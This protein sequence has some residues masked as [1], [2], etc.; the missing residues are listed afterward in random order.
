MDGPTTATIS[1]YSQPTGGKIFSNRANKQNVCLGSETINVSLH[2]KS[3]T[4]ERFVVKK[5]YKS[6][7]TG[8]I[9]LL[10]VYG[11]YLSRRTQNMLNNTILFEDYITAYVRTGMVPVSFIYNE[12]WCGLI[13]HFY[14]YSEMGSLLGSTQRRTI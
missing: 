8:D 2:A 5:D 14:Y 13:Q 3:K 9:Q 11:T 6:G 7:Q 4:T 12:K 10:V 1:I